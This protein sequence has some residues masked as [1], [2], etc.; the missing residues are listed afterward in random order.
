MTPPK[1]DHLPFRCIQGKYFFIHST[2][3]QYRP[4]VII[5]F[6]HVS[7]CTSA[8]VPNFQNIAKQNKQW[9]LLVGQWVW[10]RGSLKTNVLFPLFCQVKNHIALI[11][12]ADPQS[13]PVAI[14][15]SRMLSVWQ[16]P[17]L[18]ILQNKV[19]Q[20]KIVK[21]TGGNLDLTQGIFGNTC[22]ANN[23]LIHEADHSPGR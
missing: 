6:A 8:S 12:F 2:D 15:I 5:I 16:S 14:T 20:L 19:N 4:V 11:H 9:P 21:A 18:K 23:L 13:G 10:P 1:L 22:L 3:L 17:L 7:V